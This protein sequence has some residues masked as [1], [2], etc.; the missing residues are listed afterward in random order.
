[1]KI[2]FFEIV[3]V[4]MG[5]YLLNADHQVYRSSTSHNESGEHAY[6]KL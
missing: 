3:M 5:T 2:L 1:M 6:R 4:W